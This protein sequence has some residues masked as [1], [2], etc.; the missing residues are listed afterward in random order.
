VQATGT[1]GGYDFLQMARRFGKQGEARLAV[2]DSIEEGRVKGDE[3][4]LT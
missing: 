3:M 2:H 1:A 4:L